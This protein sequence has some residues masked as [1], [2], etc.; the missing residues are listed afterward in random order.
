[1][2]KALLDKQWDIIICDYNL[3][4]LKAPLVIALLRETNTNVPLIIISGING[5]E[6][7]VE[8]MRLGVQ[9]YIMKSDFSRLCPAVARQLEEA[10]TRNKQR[11][12][13]HKVKQPSKLC[14]RAR[15]NIEPFWEIL[16][17]VIT[18]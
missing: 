12:E 1:M 5:E 15:K 6:T 9:D 10:K 3:P 13:I 17:K 7:A 18:K 16:K 4:K 11:Q 8:C 2:K 14:A